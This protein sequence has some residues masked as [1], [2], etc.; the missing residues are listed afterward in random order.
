[1][2]LRGVVI[3]TPRLKGEGLEG[4]GAV[5]PR[6]ILASKKA[7]G[8]ACRISRHFGDDSFDA[9]SMIS[10]TVE[11]SARLKS[12]SFPAFGRTGSIARVGV[13]PSPR[14]DKCNS[15]IGFIGCLSVSSSDCPEDPDA[16]PAVGAARKG[17]KR[18]ARPLRAATAAGRSHL[19]IFLAR[20]LVRGVL[21][22]LVRG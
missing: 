9:Q 12:A 11:N 10:E 13:S 3:C 2:A 7:R 17:A 5:Q 19:L 1:M 21:S 20:F 18:Q 14:P 4:R 6:L 8:I 15:R 22:P 16:G